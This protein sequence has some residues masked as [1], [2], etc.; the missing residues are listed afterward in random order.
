CTEKPS[1]IVECGFLS[2]EEDERLLTTNEYRE[3]IAYSIAAGL[4]DY[5]K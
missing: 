4:T 3:E 1:V 2:N 5:Y